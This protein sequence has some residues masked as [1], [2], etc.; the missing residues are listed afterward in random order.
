MQEEKKKILQMVQDGAITV[1][2]AYSI[3]DELEKAHKESEQKE[4]NLL[5]ELSTVV[6]NK[7]VPK[8]NDSL[9]KKVQ[10]SKEKILGFVGTAIQKIKDTDLDFNFGTSQEISHIFQDL[11]RDL[12]QVEIEIANGKL[13]IETW[14]QPDIRIECAAK[15]Y[16]SETQ[17]QAREEFLKNVHFTNEEGR[18]RFHVLQKSVKVDAKIFVPIR[19][20]ESIS[21]RLFNGGITGGSLLVDSLKAK[22]A[23]GAITLQKVEGKKCDVET[24]NGKITI[25]DSRLEIVEAESLNGAIVVNGHYQ[26]I[27]AQSFNGQISCQVLEPTCESIQ[28]KSVTGSIVLQLPSGASADGELK[29]NLGS[30]NISL[31][32]ID[33]IEEKSDVIQKVLKFKTRKNTLPSLHLFADTKTGAITVS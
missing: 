28:A 19:H 21:V 5:N 25:N 15:V 16:N 10:F 18:V 17:A 33:V 8:E 6:L 4:E 3:L 32:G 20:Y 30:F 1:E 11:P 27:D 12:K 13:A 14:D 7:D 31:G 22:T 23:N 24:G 2:E 29:S 26:Q 9:N